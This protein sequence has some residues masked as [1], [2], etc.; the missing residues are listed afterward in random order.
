MP[1]KE[2]LPV[3]S[4]SHTKHIYTFRGQNVEFVNIS[5]AGTWGNYLVL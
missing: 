2:T 3:S 1:Y 5:P 4:D